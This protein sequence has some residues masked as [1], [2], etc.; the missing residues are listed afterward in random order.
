M[1]EALCVFL[2]TVSIYLVARPSW[3]RCVAAGLL[4][5]FAAYCRP[6]LLPLG[7]V[8]AAG[9]ATAHRKFRPAL[10]VAAFSVVALV[11]LSVWNYTHFRKFTPLPALGGSGVP[12]FYG[13]WESVLPSAQLT[14]FYDGEPP[15]KLLIKSGMVAQ[16]RKINLAVGTTPDNPSPF[17]LCSVRGSERADQLLRA[18]T[19]QD[20]ERWPGA[21][22]WHEA[23]VG[24]TNWLPTLALRRFPQPLRLLLWIDVVAVPLLGFIGL[25]SLTRSSGEGRLLGFVGLAAVA[26][27]TV[28]LGWFVSQSRYTVPLRLVL[29]LGAAVFVDE[30]MG[31]RRRL[32]TNRFGQERLG[33]DGPV[34]VEA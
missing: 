31:G 18:A 13:V 8:V 16:L 20:A 26:Y 14:E 11:P 7:F 30:L 10:L 9:M 23:R 34:H 25:I 17:P 29:L 27:F 24:V 12:L 19:V 21:Y 3:I 1:T 33:G 5:G 6:N 22:L 4:L 2:V 28:S 15:S 32:E